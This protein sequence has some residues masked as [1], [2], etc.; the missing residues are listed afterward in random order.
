MRRLPERWRRDRLKEKPLGWFVNVA[1]LTAVAVV[2][3]GSPPVVGQTEP[4]T[5]TLSAPQICETGHVGEA[6]GSHIT[7]GGSR[8]ISRYGWRIMAGPAGEIDVDWAVRGG[9][10]PYTLTID[11]ETQDR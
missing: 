3:C 8:Q 4:L 9:V 11:G 1:L 5:L 6:L 2:F 7:E 10:A